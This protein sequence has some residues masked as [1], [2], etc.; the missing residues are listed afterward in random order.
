MCLIKTLAFL[1]CGAW[2]S[3]ALAA[4]V[5]LENLDG[6]NEGFNDNSP[7]I[8]NQ[9]NNPGTTLGEQRLAV[10]QAAAD[11][12]GARLE[13]DVIIRISINMDPLFC[14][15][16]SASLGQAGAVTNFANFPNAPRPDTFYPVALANSL[17]G[18]DLSPSA[19]SANNDIQ[20]TFNLSLIH[21]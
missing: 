15:A 21:I 4:T 14:S 7:P 2:F 10:I 18:Q 3:P 16:F 5:I 6:P 19:G 9:P 11:F 17:A 13:S 20:A 12:W 8:A 1:L